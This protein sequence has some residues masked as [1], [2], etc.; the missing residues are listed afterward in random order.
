MTQSATESKKMASFVRPLFVF[1]A[2]VAA[3]LVTGCDVDQE[4]PQP[5]AAEQVTLQTSMPAE[6][7]SALAA[8]QL[9]ET[10]PEK[11]AMRLDQACRVEIDSYCGQV[12]PGD[13]R[14]A[15]CLYAHTDLL[16]DN[17]YEVTERVGVILEGVFDGMAAFYAACQVDLQQWCEDALPG[18]GQQVQCLRSHAAEISPGCSVALPMGSK[19][20]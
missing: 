19:A 1:L 12:T 11:G 15:S 4:L 6:S 10:L 16:T 5:V 13:G 8:P 2:L 17:C 18:T 9:P 14:V 3:L 7:E 20:R